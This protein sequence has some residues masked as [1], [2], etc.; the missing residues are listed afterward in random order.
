MDMEAIHVDVRRKDDVLDFNADLQR[1]K[2]LARLL[3]SEFS[4]AGVRFGLD[5][6]V[7]LVPVVGDTVSFIAGIYPI[8]LARKHK[9]G[10]AVELRMWGNLIIDYFGGLVPIA[11]D[12]FDVAFKANLKN[13][14]LLEKAAQRS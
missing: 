3:D 10:R 8:H 7:G 12:A 2:I 4:L 14:E 1:A 5:A 11:G 13:V 9:L 6:I